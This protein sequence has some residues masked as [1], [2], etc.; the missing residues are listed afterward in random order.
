MD[1]IECM[2]LPGYT[3]KYC[4]FATAFRLDGTYSAQRQILTQSNDKNVDLKFDFKVKFFHQL[5][6]QLPLVYLTTA[7]NRL[8]LEVTVHR[9]YLRIANNQLGILH[10]LAFYYPYFGDSRNYEDIWHSI[11]I[12]L[13]KNKARIVYSVAALHLSEAKLIDFGTDKMLADAFRIG[14][15][16][17]SVDDDDMGFLSGAC[18]RDV[19]LDGI[20]VFK[21]N[22]YV[23]IDPHVAQIIKFGCQ[24]SNNTCEINKCNNNSTCVHRWYNYECTQCPVSFYGRNCHLKVQKLGFIQ[25]LAE[26]VL[27]PTTTTTTTSYHSNKQAS[28]MFKISFELT[29]ISKLTSSGNGRRPVYFASLKQAD[30]Y[31]MIGVDKSGF[32]NLKRVFQRGNK[33]QWSLSNENFNLNM[34]SSVRVS[35]KLSEQFIE[36]NLNDEFMSRFE[37][38]DNKPRNMVGGSVVEPFRID[39]IKFSN[40]LMNSSELFLVNDL[41]VMDRRYEFRNEQRQFK[42]SV[43]GNGGEVFKVRRSSNIILFESNIENRKIVEFLNED[44]CDLIDGYVSTGFEYSVC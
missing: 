10:H 9:H 28:N 37:I 38:V 44:F 12:K 42:V 14:Q 3:G 39:E 40:T 13:N 18:I 4:Q 30:Y 23:S 8:L 1:G 43:I 7:D 15:L 36:I 25:P 32:V 33:I 22:P 24:H 5:D 31:Y 34:V 16:F 17:N 6:N 21:V 35:L 20:Y 29:R 19:V 41:R 2:C 11:S 26:L 27:V